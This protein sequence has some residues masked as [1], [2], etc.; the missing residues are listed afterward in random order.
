MSATVSEPI[1]AVVGLQAE[2]RLLRRLPWKVEVGGGAP[3]GAARAARSLIAGG[4]RA[5]VSFGLAG[6]LDPALTPGTLIIPDA[7]LFEG[8][9]F[10]ADASLLRELG[11]S[12]RHLLLGG[13][14][15]LTRRVEKTRAFE[16]TGAHA[17]DL[18]SG[19]VARVASER[20]LGFAALRAICDPASRDLPPLVAEALGADGGLDI[21]RICR[22][23]LARPGQLRSL[24]MLAADAM[25][26]RRTL[27]SAA[28]RI[29]R[30]A[31]VA[32]AATAN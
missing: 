26:A 16:R 17:I 19:P 6:G 8:V 31:P 3:Q 18:E 32:G 20:G 4:A 9:R 30:A 27:Q 22:S 21:A 24:V 15:V 13:T 10:P 25:M 28:R 7:V 12:T 2:A 29:A 23:L 1:G 5:L 11:G 14:A